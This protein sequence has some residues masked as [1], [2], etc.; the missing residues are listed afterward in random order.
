[1][2]SRYSE[3][4]FLEA[5]EEAKIGN[6]TAACSKFETLLSDNSKNT[7]YTC[8]INMA[9]LKFQ[10]GLIEESMNLLKKAR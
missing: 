8:F 5:L 6:L 7:K 3:I 10:Q 9:V 1:M 2:A 4:S